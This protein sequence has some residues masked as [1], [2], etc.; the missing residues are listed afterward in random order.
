MEE[1]YSKQTKY[2]SL[3]EWLAGHYLPKIE[4]RIKESEDKIF[5]IERTAVFNAPSPAPA[6][7]GTV[8][9]AEIIEEGPPEPEP[10]IQSADERRAQEVDH[11]ATDTRPHASC[12]AVAR[13]NAR[14]CHQTPFR[15]GDHRSLGSRNRGTCCLLDVVAC[16]RL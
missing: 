16:G 10:R 8:I 6:P 7:E 12:P 5:E 14:A 15:R 13:D 11:P 1:L 9:H 2:G 4:R 3:A